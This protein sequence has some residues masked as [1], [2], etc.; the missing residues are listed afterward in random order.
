MPRSA[1]VV[2]CLLLALAA[3]AS[4]AGPY[5]GLLKYTPTSTNTLLL[6]DA[7]GAYAS[8]LAKSEKWSE[9]GQPGNRG[10]LGFV[11]SDAEAVVVAADVN[12]NTLVR[13]CQVGL[14]TVGSL[15][16]MRDVATREGG[17]SDDIVGQVAALSPR[18]VYFTWLPSTTLVAVYPADRQFTARYLKS[19]LANKTGT[20]S[21]YL[22]KA[23]EGAKDNTV[24]IA[25]DLEDAVDKT[26]LKMALPTSPAVAKIKNADVN[27]LASFLSQVKGMTFSAKVTDKITAS[28][29]IE[30]AV[31]PAR[32]RNTLPDLV[33][34][35]I[36]DQ[37]IAI[38][39]FERWKPEFKDTTFT[40]SGSLTT[41]D[42]KHIVSL[43]AFPNP[44]AE[45]EPGTTGATPTAS[46]T[47]RYLQAV[48][49]ILGEIAQKKDSPNYDKTATWH[50]K[51][52]DQLLHISPRNV[53]PVA[54]D[55]AHQSARRLRAIGQSLRGVPIDTKALAEQQYFYGYG[56]G[57]SFGWWGGAA[58]FSNPVFVDTNIPK[59]REQMAKVVSDDKQHRAETWEM[60]DKTIYDAKRKLAE[61]YKVSF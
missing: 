19:A 49:T 46:A 5:D 45:P 16:N 56:G 13:G 54:I 26:I 61:K 40:L 60:I 14:V 6:V 52:A 47:K 25:V 38:E 15:P 2:W 37:G 53:D 20:L 7:K 24:T 30:F 11:P 48:N 44:A 21:P 33:R 58:L 18:D 51:A 32:F 29:A 36:E 22:K 27:L 1:P 43:F 28:I 8:P 59:I 57:R 9:K 42:L 35:L 39:G 34:E 41:A 50:D 3:P 4:A 23:T 12:L 31:E 55:A 17:S 10:G